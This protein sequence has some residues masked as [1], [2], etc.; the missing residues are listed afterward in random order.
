MTILTHFDK[1]IEEEMQ[2]ALS[3]SS[4]CGPAVQIEGLEVL[5][6]SHHSAFSFDSDGQNIC[7]ELDGWYDDEEED[8]LVLARNRIE[9]DAGGY[10][11]QEEDSLILAGGKLGHKERVAGF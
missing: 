9:F 7:D 3:K 2:A 11:S 6:G 1:L 5:H 4:A 10:D 8:S